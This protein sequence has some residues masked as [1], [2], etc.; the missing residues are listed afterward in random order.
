MHS[1]AAFRSSNPSS[2]LCLNGPKLTSRIRDFCDIWGAGMEKGKMV[3][4][5]IDHS[6]NGH[7]GDQD[8]GKQC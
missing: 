6:G 4:G 3:D 5:E 1:N 2:T 8:S 7:G